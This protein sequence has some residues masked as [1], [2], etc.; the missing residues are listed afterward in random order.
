MQSVACEEWSQDEAIPAQDLG[1]NQT[2]PG[3]ATQ[4][5]DVGLRLQD[6]GVPQQWPPAS[7]THLQPGTVAQASEYIGQVVRL[8]VPTQ[9]SSGPP[10]GTPSRLPPPSAPPTSGASAAPPSRAPPKPMVP[11][12]LAV[13]P[14]PAAPPEPVIPPVRA[15]LALPP[16]PPP[17]V[18]P[19]SVAEL[20][21]EPPPTPVIPPLA[22]PPV[23]TGASAAAS[24]EDAFVLL[25]QPWS[26]NANAQ[27]TT[28]N[29]Q[30]TRWNI[31]A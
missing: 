6:A 7:A 20:P 22:V 3:F 2:Q 24:G 17:A 28:I 25:P 29:H 31:N 10:S 19:L 4:V 30:E 18:P 9:R 15:V 23:D 8:D 16:A 27:P 21:V 13:P 5:A 26:A 1:A 12:V 14:N 11:P